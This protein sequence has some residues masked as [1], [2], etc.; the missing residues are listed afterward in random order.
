[1]RETVLRVLIA[2]WAGGAA[3]S[4]HATEVLTVGPAGDYASIQAALMAAASPPF[5]TI[6]VTYE[7]RVQRAVYA[8]NL[9]LPSP[10]CG[11]LTIKIVGGWNS[12]FTSRVTDPALTVVDGRG[13]GR[14]FTAANLNSGSVRLES[15]TI[16][17][18]LVRAGGSYGVGTGAGVRATLSGTAL[19]TLARVQVRSNIIRAEAPG[20]AEAQGAGAMVLLEGSSNLLVTDSRF[21]INSIVQA[22][23]SL[24]SYGGG[25]HIQAFER[26]GATIWRTEFL[27]NLASGSRISQ[28]G[29]VYAL[30]QGDRAG[31][32]M[33]DVLMHANVVSNPIGEGAALTVNAAQGTNLGGVRL[34]RCRL[35]NNIGGGSQL[36]ASVQDGSN[37]H[38][39]DSLVANGRGGIRAFVHSSTARFTNLTIAD[40]ELRGM[41][42]SVTG[43]QLSV[44]N[45]IAFGNGG[46]NL[47]VSGTTFTSGF[48]LVGV[49]P[50]FRDPEAG[51]YQL[52]GASL[53]L[54][55]GTNDPPGLLGIADLARLDRV[56]NGTVDI[57]AY[58][59]Q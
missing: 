25:L 31:L 53:A 40:N 39:H 44:F 50:I 22:G 52:D 55:A 49:D 12:T 58:E 48:N 8:E 21:F 1:M 36:N 20:N 57:G 29:G 47:S 54:D 15:L 45:T 23:S 26:G 43:G 37:L 6:P 11:P 30:L 16:R 3:V 35:V 2:V 9:R 59:F 46:G 17:D 4:A 24:A 56:V 27:G 41:Q 19:L 10:C 14:V 18:G 5:G 7:I 33:E 34:D 38:F 13:L 51:D 32:G 42:G 28:G